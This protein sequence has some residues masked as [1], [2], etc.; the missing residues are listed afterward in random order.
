MDYVCLQ[1]SEQSEGSLK[2]LSEA[3]T[4]LSLLVTCG[5]AGG[6]RGG[7]HRGRVW[8]YLICP[9]G[10]SPEEGSL[11]AGEAG[12][13]PDRP[14]EGKR[15][16]DSDRT[17]SSAGASGFVATAAGH[18]GQRR[19]DPGRL[20]RSGGACEEGGRPRGGQLTGGLLF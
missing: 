9:V 17:S 6:G 2:P 11:S 12:R 15:G 7:S 16:A 1:R 13:G 18:G 20:G 14:G 5:L 8:P 3:P 19:R 10:P 4:P